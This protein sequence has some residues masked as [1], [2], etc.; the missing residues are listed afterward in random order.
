MGNTGGAKGGM[1]VIKNETNG[2]IIPKVIANFHV[3]SRL[4]SITGKNIG[5]NAAPSPNRWKNCGRI[6]PAAAN[7]AVNGICLR[8]VSFIGP[9]HYNLKSIPIRAFVPGA[10]YPGRI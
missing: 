5:K 10:G 8:S 7:I 9:H 2:V 6:T 3:S 4:P 1:E